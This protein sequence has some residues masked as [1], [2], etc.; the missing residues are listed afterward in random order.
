MY[1]DHGDV[2]AN[3]HVWMQQDHTKHVRSPPH[4]VT[5][6]NVK[7]AKIDL[8]VRHNIERQRRVQTS[9]S[10]LCSMYSLCQA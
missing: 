8:G 4:V 7:Q 3:I 1:L 5:D 10:D 9:A 2:L 6:A